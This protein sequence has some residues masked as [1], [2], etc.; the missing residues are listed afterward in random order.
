MARKVF[1]SFLGTNNY[2]ETYYELN[3]EKSKPVR[4]IQEALIDF[5]C[6][7]WTSED[8]I[9]IFYTD[10]DEGSKKKNWLDNGQE[11]AKEEIEKIGLQS[12][13]K[14]MELKPIIE[15]YDVPEGFSESEIW[16]IFDCVYDKLLEND[17]IYF[18]VTHA[19]R[20]I[21]LFSSVLFNYSHYMKKTEIESIHYGAFEKLGPAYKVKSLSLKDRVAPILNL[22]NII[23]LQ[24]L[25]ETASGL[26]TFGRI[27]RIGD[28]INEDLNGTKNQSINRIVNAIS[29]LDDDINANRMLDIRN[30]Q[31]MRDF[32]ANI[33]SLQ[34]SDLPNPTKKIVEKLKTELLGFRPENCLDNVAVAVCW[35]F[36]YEMI[37][38]AYTLAQE[39]IISVVAENLKKS[40]DLDENDF[41]QERDFRLYISSLLAISDKDVKDGNFREPLIS[42]ISL[43]KKILNIQWIIELRKPFCKFAEGRN[44]V[45]HAKGSQTASDIKNC[46]EENYNSCL[47]ILKSNNLC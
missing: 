31:Y 17:H 29:I 22:T 46:F 1:I 28:E 27:K 39:Y 4:F 32:E 8:R 12:R 11:S 45:D 2:I 44:I 3:G 42:K 5:L 7:D 38:Q 30:G 10:G 15:H 34:N 36:K 20:S 13:L 43:T 25:T 23:K 9:I 41:S 35:A 21:P 33:R 19:F 6:K 24:Q 37:P 47:E 16:R 40:V 18:D 14:K 26:S